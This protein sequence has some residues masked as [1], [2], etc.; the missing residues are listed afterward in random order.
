LPAEYRQK[1]IPDSA[2][3]VVLEAGVSMGWAEVGGANTLMVA[4]DRFGESAPAAEI[5]EHLGFTAEAVAERIK[6]LL[7]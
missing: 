6:P 4:I 1:L 2:A 3:R 7:S 5:A